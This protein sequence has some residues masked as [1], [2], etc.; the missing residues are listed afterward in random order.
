MRRFTVTILIVATLLAINV[1]G[2]SVRQPSHRRGNSGRSLGRDSRLGEI[3]NGMRQILDF[4]R[5]FTKPLIRSTSACPKLNCANHIAAHC[6]RSVYYNIKGKRCAG[7]DVDICKVQQR[8]RKNTR[9]VPVRRSEMP[10]FI[11]RI[12]ADDGLMQFENRWAQPR[13]IDLM[14]TNSFDPIQNSLMGGGFALD[15]ARRDADFPRGWEN[16]WITS[17][18]M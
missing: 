15:D 17:P 12:K 14:S 7:C 4:A 10:I 1:C 5:E 3:L 16:S 9:I 18:L 11:P 6:R 8:R 13:E 2:S